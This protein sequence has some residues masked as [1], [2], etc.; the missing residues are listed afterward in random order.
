MYSRREYDTQNV[1]W[2]GDLG[3]AALTS[4]ET[5]HSAW[6]PLTHPWYSGKNS[7]GVFSQ[8]EFDKIYLGNSLAANG[9]FIYSIFEKNR[10][11]ESGIGGLST[12]FTS[13]RFSTVAGYAGR[14]FYSG[15]NSNR[16]GLGSRVY[17]SQLIIDNFEDIGKCY[18]RNDPTSEEFSDLLDTDGGFISIP[19]ANNIKKLH[20][21]GPTL[22]VF[23]DNGVWAISGVDDVFRASEYSVSKLT[24]V[25]LK[26]KNTF[27][28]A[29]GRPYWWSEI[30]IHTLVL[31]DQ[32]G[33]IVEQDISTP[34]IRTFWSALTTLQKTKSVAAY[35][36]FNSRVVWMYPITE[37]SGFAIRLKRFLVFDE[38]F[39]A[40]YPWQVEGLDHIIGA[41]YDPETIT[42]QENSSGLKFLLRD[43]SSGRVT[44]GGFTDTTFKDFTD[45]DYDCY[46]V[47]GYDFLGDLTIQKNA[48]FVTIYLNR[49]ETGF[50]GTD[51]LGY[52][53]VR[54]SSCLVSA[55]WDF[56]TAPS[57]T[58]QAYR[59]KFPAV[60]DTGNLNTF[61]YPTTVVTSRL[62]VR[63]RGR[64]F[65]LKFEAENGKDL[66]LYG[67]EV[68]GSRNPTP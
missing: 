22:Y 67:F 7:S 8:S 60:P 63:G 56:A 61:N 47:A 53:V 65:R 46:A 50:T 4:Y 30:G 9:H 6:P 19:E 20:V 3:S 15:L 11:T 18:Q 13:A 57:S 29:N 33:T 64:S 40:F 17:F 14:V 38:V 39:S 27:V 1:G 12:D 43:A 66:H 37:S 26:Y 55:F 36:G 51:A 62:K 31:N 2:V 41:V 35:D 52:E 16:K 49:T 28:S 42:S 21:F 34:T 48:P 24:E 10:A 58:Q 44:W 54:G 32:I 5:H 25:G 59:L 68:L 45:F 23:A